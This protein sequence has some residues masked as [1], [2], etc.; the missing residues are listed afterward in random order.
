MEF[1]ENQDNRVFTRTCGVCNRL[2]FVV[3]NDYTGRD[4]PYNVL[5]GILGAVELDQERILDRI[6][7]LLYIQDCSV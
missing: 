1:I 7:N 3:L 5:D 6:E 4:E 2:V